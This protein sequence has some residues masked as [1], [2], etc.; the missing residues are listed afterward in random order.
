[1]HHISYSYLLS[2]AATTQE[3][4]VSSYFADM[5]MQLFL[6]LNKYNPLL[7]SGTYSPEEPG[8]V[9]T[10]LSLLVARDYNRIFLPFIPQNR[11]FYGPL[12]MYK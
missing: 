3:G 9:S 1:M 2:S 10:K 5:L 8:A 7:H 4:M 6:G 12:V 11:H